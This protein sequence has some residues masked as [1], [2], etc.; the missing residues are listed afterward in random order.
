MEERDVVEGSLPKSGRGNA[1]TDSGRGYA[2]PDSGRGDEVPDV[3]RGS[4]PEESRGDAG[5]MSGGTVVL[6]L[7]LLRVLSPFLIASSSGRAK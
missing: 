6:V 3:I 5:V 1:T 2:A 7:Q 4:A